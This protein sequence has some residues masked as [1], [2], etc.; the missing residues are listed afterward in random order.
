MSGQWTN[1][2]RIHHRHWLASGGCASKATGLSSG[3]LPLVS[4][5][6]LRVERFTLTVQQKSAAGVAHAAYLAQ[7]EW[8][9]APVER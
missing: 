4:E 8:F 6:G 5:S 1:E 9:A 2:V 7:L 3:D